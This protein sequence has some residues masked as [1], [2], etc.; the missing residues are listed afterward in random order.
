LPDFKIR[1]AGGR[2][3]KNTGFFAGGGT[4]ENFCLINLCKTKN[5]G[6]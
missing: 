1:D 6:K 3:A 5:Y 4:G 2:T